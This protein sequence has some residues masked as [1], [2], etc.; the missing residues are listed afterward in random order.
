M[1]TEEEIEEIDTQLE[2]EKDVADMEMG[3]ETDQEFR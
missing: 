1:Q 3:D 2:M